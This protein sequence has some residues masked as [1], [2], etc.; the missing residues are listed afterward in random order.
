L[1]ADFDSAAT[2]NRDATQRGQ[3][4]LGPLALAARL[5]LIFVLVTIGLAAAVLIG[6]FGL[7]AGFGLLVA[8]LLPLR[9]PA[10]TSAATGPEGWV[11]EAPARVLDERQTA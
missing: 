4:R 9:Q 5:A 3:K 1:N 8:R 10:Q 7:V 6:L 2:H 11:I